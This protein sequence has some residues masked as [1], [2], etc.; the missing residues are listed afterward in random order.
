M[1]SLWITPAW[2]AMVIPV[3]MSF[4]K[5]SALAISIGLLSGIS[6]DSVCDGK[7]SIEIA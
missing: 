5:R 6:P 2:C 7:Y 3:A 4:E 1:R